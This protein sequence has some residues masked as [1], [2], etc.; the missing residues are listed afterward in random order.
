LTLAVQSSSVAPVTAASSATAPLPSS[1]RLSDLPRLPCDDG[2]PVFAEPWQAQAFALA[3][4]L[5]EQGLFTWKEWAAALAEE[6][7]A[8]A[9]RGEPD[10]GSRYYEHWLTALERLVTSRGLTDR[11]ALVAR[12][13]AWATAYRVTPHGTPVDL[14]PPRPDARWLLL[15]IVGTCAGYWLIHHIDLV[16]LRDWGTGAIGAGAPTAVPPVGF[17]ASAALGSLLGMQHAFEPDH[18]A[19][20]ATLMTGERTSAKAAWLG[21]CWGLGHTLTLLAGGIALVVCRAEMPPLLADT[22][23]LSV[24]LLLVGFGARA[25]YLA[26][27]GALPRRTHSHATPARSSRIAAIDRWT[28]ARPLLVGAAHGLAGSGAL[29]TLV[30]AT[31]PSTA[32]RLGYLALFGIGSTLGMVALSG[33]LGWQI[34]RMGTDRA[35]VRAFSLAVGCASAV[36]GLFWGYPL[37]DRMF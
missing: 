16:S 10:D 11:T 1:S 25:I 24:V 30:V 32:T 17:A 28:L 37:L 5:S 3:V 18:L 15:G 21:A 12:R 13:D 9:R 8:A 22:F 6:L 2:G 34:A 23:E 29:T 14:A 7:Q 4:K 36:L 26:A 31:L 27:C 20:V 35:V 19:A 33:L